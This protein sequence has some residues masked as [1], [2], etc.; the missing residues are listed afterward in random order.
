MYENPQNFLPPPDPRM[1]PQ[2]VPTNPQ[3]A[4]LAQSMALPSTMPNPADP[5]RQRNNPMNLPLDLR[6]QQGYYTPYGDAVVVGSPNPT[7]LP[8]PM[9]MQNIGP[10]RLLN[11]A[12]M[13]A[14]PSPPQV[15]PAAEFAQAQLEQLR[16]PFAHGA[17]PGGVPAPAVGPRLNDATLDAMGGRGMDTRSGRRGAPPPP[18]RK[19]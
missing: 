16:A 9:P 10:G 19:S 11:S 13:G 12:P 5:R 3:L 7:V 14:L 18:P 15:G 17:P 4:G 8:N 1:L 6:T 2:A